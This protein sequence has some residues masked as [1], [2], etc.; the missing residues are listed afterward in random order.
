MKRRIGIVGSRCELSDSQV[1]KLVE[2]VWTARDH[3]DVIV[4]G[5]C[6]TGADA[7]VRKQCEA[8]GVPCTVHKLHPVYGK[9]AE[10]IRNQA[11]VDDSY[12]LHAFWDGKSRGT[13]DAIKRARSA[14]M[15]VM[16]Y[17]P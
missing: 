2:V 6:P 7:E 4:T 1:S 15:A 5:D 14:G 12:E 3:Q 11:L 9:V 10:R 17:K 16:V 13:A 8:L